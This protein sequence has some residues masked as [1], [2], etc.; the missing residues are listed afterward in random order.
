MEYLMP[1][2][3]AVGM[4]EKYLL[5]TGQLKWVL[6]NIGN[7]KEGFIRANKLWNEAICVENADLIPARALL[8]QFRKKKIYLDVHNVPRNLFG[9]LEFEE[10]CIVICLTDMLLDLNNR[11]LLISHEFRLAHERFTECVIQIARSRRQTRNVLEISRLDGKCR[12]RNSSNKR[13]V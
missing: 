10:K 13:I 1:Q 4:H 6:I 3:G 12:Y 5:W 9:V 8:N 7:G 2:S 11:T